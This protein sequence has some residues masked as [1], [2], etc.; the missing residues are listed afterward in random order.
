MNN[1]LKD[2]IARAK[3]IEMKV[4]KKEKYKNKKDDGKKKRKVVLFHAKDKI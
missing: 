2:I 4:K 3:R 1:R